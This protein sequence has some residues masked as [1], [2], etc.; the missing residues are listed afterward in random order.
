MTKKWTTGQISKLLETYPIH[1]TAA[2]A[3]MLG[4]PENVIRNKID[5]LRK[6]G[7]K[8]KIDKSSTE[9]KCTKCC[10]V[11]SL[12]NFFNS[13]KGRNGKHA[14]CKSCFA[15]RDRER[16]SQDNFFRLRKML[17]RRYKFVSDKSFTNERKV[18]FGCDEKDFIDHIEKQ[19]DNTMNW[20]TNNWEL[21]H[22][23]PI[24]V[25]RKYPEKMYL[26]FN[27]RNHQ[28]LF[29]IENNLK[30]D[31]LAIS[32]MH[33][34]RKIELFGKDDFYSEMLEFLLESKL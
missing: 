6:N 10:Q 24:A 5:N 21:D 16:Y 17:R 7:R 11:K 1:G 22:I 20:N 13:S 29:S 26:V 14:A 12:D 32:I 3:E 33:L 31:N 34:Q 9:Q 15:E 30:S 18:I 4:I 2:T 8:L 23:I 28:P 19:F 25:L 27:Y